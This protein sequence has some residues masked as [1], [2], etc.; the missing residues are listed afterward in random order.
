[1]IYVPREPVVILGAARTPQGPLDGSVARFSATQLGGFAIAAALKRA[2]IAPDRVD[3][4]VMGNVVSAG[5]RQSPAKQ[6]A[7]AAGIPQDRPSKTVNTVCASGM[8]AVLDAALS[9][10]ARVSEIV[11][12]GGMESRSNAPY[13]LGPYT[14]GGTRLGGKVRGT[15]FLL[16]MPKA[17]A[18]VDQWRSFAEMLGSAGLREA[19]IWDSL[20]CPFC[21]NTLMK[22]YAAKYAEEKGLSIEEINAAAADSYEKAR[23]AQDSGAFAREIT[24]AGGVRDDDIISPEYEADV[25]A[26]SYGCVTAY[27]APALGDG[28]S[29]VVLAL[30]KT[31]TRL[32]LQ[33][34]ARITA[35]SR[36]DTE[37]IGFVHAPVEA[38]A[39]LKSATGVQ[40]T[41]VEANESFGL[42][43]PVFRREFGADVI[44]P[45]GG[46]VALTHPVGASGARVIVTLLNA[47]KAFGHKHGAATICFGSGGA[48]AVSVERL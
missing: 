21:A 24:P 23:A 41:I 38:I 36:I 5:I 34:M 45:Y 44:N 10:A 19:D 11:V 26:L 31:A 27:N 17:D 7:V 12:A 15:D 8:T 35:F 1:M 39:A 4:C 32:G 42:Q 14:A 37:P 46:A 20:L 29:A 30:G 3:E 33:A 47:M 18:P 22:D 9:L 40:P 6:A 16:Q 25:K 43:I 2:G 13:Y 48:T 28:A